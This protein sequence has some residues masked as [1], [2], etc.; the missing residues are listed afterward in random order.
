MYNL[1]KVLVN[2]I[3]TAATISKSQSDINRLKAYD[4]TL[5]SLDLRMCRITSVE[6]QEIA[7]ALV[8]NE[9]LCSLIL[10]GNRISAEAIGTLAEALIN[11][12]K[13]QE[14]NLRS[15]RLTMDGVDSIAR[16]LVEN[17]VL[18]KLYLGNSGI[19]VEGVAIIANALINN[20]SLITLD[21]SNNQIGVEGVD[22][23]IKGLKSNK[24]LCELYYRNIGAN[25]EQSKL[26]NAILNKNKKNIIYNLVIKCIT[27]K[28]NYDDALAIVERKFSIFNLDMLQKYIKKIYDSHLQVMYTPFY[29]GDE[30]GALVSRLPMELNYH[31]AKYI[32]P[33]AD[34]NY[35]SK[36]FN[37]A[38]VLA[39]HKNT[40]SSIRTT[41]QQNI[42]KPF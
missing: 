10:C 22:I 40:H 25:E 35:L 3:L 6:V 12:H 7:E 15:V 29:F 28:V 31:I 42:P 26:I 9:F 32:M 21:L 20:K 38:F 14:L 16:L 13:L 4:P 37:M 18:N 1:I 39:E 11:N 30:N 27:N 23:L 36:A 33:K 8:E 19:G 2:V 41:A 24:T 34:I 5:V 17:A